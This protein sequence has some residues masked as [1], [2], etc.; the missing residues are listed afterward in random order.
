MNVLV[1]KGRPEDA[2]AASIL[3]ARAKAS[4]GYAPEW[5]ALWRDVLTIRPEYLAEHLSF[6]A[7][8]AGDLVGI[9]VLETRGQLASLGHLWVAPEVQRQGIGRTLVR[10]ALVQAARAG[11]KR[12]EVE[13]EPSAAEFYL[14]LGARS[15]GHRP[16]PMPGAPERLL[17]VLE[18]SLDEFSVQ[19]VNSEP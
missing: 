17:P 19:E 13:A 4:V 5:L 9:C 14:R 1:R 18:F 3:A 11:L 16:A 7:M 6:V 12:V 2:A 15:C 8:H 10:Q